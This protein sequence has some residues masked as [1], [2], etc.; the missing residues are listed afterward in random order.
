MV[1]TVILYYQQHTRED[2]IKLEIF[3][4]L[5]RPIEPT[6]IGIDAYELEF[7]AMLVVI[8]KLFRFGFDTLLDI[9]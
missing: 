9:P 6:L 5:I 7:V 3:R 8:L 2:I 1:G 4:R